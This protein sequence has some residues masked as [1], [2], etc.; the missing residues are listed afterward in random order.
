MDPQRGATPQTRKSGAGRYVFRC[1]AEPIERHHMTFLVDVH[2]IGSRQTGNETLARNLSR[3]LARIAAPDELVFAASEAGRSEVAALT[4][5]TPRVVADSPVRRLAI[6]LPRMAREVNAD[7]LLVQY[8]KPI[9]RRPC[10]VMIHDL[11]PFDPRSAEWLGWRFRARVRASINYSARTAAAI[12]VPSAFTKRGLIERY[13]LDPELIAI[14]PAAVDLDLAAMLDR[15]TRG[16]LPRV[17]AVGN[18]LPRKNL[19]TLGAA[20]ARLRAAGSP[21]GLRIVGT[22]A[23]EGRP[24]ERELRGMLGDAVSF[25]GY[26]STAQLATEYA[27]A[28]VLAFPSLFEGFGI[29][30]IEAMQAGVPVVVSDTGSLPEAVGDAGLVLPPMDVEAWTVALDTV[31]H[32]DARRDELIARGHVR[33]RSLSWT[34]SATTVLETLQ[35]AAGKRPQC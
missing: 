33:A 23:T 7:A 29:P 31:L 16:E 10:V 20:I 9:T 1:D 35:R 14:A 12:V 2:H 4:G 34:A 8:T 19:T 5:S 21:V 32:D 17:I 18:V 22:V 28:D 15:P 30:A 6:D 11:S 25:T 3:E 27:A 13:D 24:I 26:V